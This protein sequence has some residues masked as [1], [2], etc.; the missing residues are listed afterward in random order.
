MFL[1]SDPILSPIQVFSTNKSI[2]AKAHFRLGSNTAGWIQ[3]VWQKLRIAR[4]L[5]QGAIVY[6]TILNNFPAFMKMPPGEPLNQ[7]DN[8]WDFPA[9]LKRR[10]NRSIEPP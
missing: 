6:A 1:R 10:S 3:L 7:C 2:G 9:A 5:L 8:A 4:N